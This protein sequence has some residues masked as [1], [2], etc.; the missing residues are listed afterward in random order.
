MLIDTLCNCDSLKGA[1]WMILA[2]EIRNKN[3]AKLANPPA[4]KNILS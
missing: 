2:G 3:R 1:D 4:E